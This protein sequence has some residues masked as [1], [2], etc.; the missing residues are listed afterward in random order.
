MRENRRFPENKEVGALMYVRLSADYMAPAF[1]MIGSGPAGLVSLDI[2][3]GLARDL[4]AWNSSYQSIILL[5]M[6]ARREPD[7]VASIQRLDREGRTLASKIA[8]EL[9]DGSKVEYFSEGLLRLIP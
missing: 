8:D 6:E 3:D 2:S 7:S 9:S 5:S 1:T 4:E